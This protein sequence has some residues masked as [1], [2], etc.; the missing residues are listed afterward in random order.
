MMEMGQFESL[1]INERVEEIT[2][3]YYETAIRAEEL[4]NESYKKLGRKAALPVDIDLIADKLDIDIVI[5]KLNLVGGNG[6]SRKLGVTTATK[7]RG[8][9]IVVDSDVSYKTRRYAIANG[10]GRYLL[11]QSKD[12]FKN[13]FE[14]PLIPQSLEEIAADAI[15]VFL[16][17]PM[18]VFKDE[19]LQYLKE[20]PK[21][22]LDVDEWLEYLSNKCQIPLFN[23]AIGYQQM[24]QVLC[25]QRRE[26]FSSYDYDVTKMPDDK[27]ESIYA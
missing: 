26:E 11:N 9:Q 20:C 16:L 14:I 17:M 13:T 12:M 25:Y 21:H 22:P 24:K 15:A 2:E 19:F 4:V 18:E 8:V 10:I 27:Y 23:L 5:E 7:D 1:G 6:F 3:V